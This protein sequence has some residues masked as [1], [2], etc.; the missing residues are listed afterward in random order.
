LD[1][2]LPYQRQD[3]IDLFRIM[4]GLPVTIRLLDPPLHEFLPHGDNEI[5]E[6]ANAAGVAEV[7]VRRRLLELSEANPMLGHRGCR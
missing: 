7:V 1:K 3:F 5:A 6:V 4:K 2:L